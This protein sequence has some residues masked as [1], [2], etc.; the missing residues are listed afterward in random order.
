[1]VA[2]KKAKENA[3]FTGT[4]NTL[5]EKLSAIRLATFIESPIQK[6]RGKYKAVYCFEEMDDDLKVLADGMGLSESKL[7]TEI[8]FSV[9]N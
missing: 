1:M 2:S 8:P 7:K 9:Y 5:L 4:I 3:A 6:T